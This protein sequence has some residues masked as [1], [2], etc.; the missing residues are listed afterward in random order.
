MPKVTIIVP[1]YN[2]EKYLK[3]CIDSLINQTLKDIEIICINDGSPDNSLKILDEYKKLDDRIVIINK[4]NEGISVARNIGIKISKGEYIGFCDSDDYVDFD[5]FE[6]LYN[7]AKENNC[8]I[9]VGGIKR[10]KDGKIKDFYTCYQS[11]FGKIFKD[12]LILTNTPDYNYVWNKIY[13]KEYLLNNNLEFEPN[14]LFED[15]RFTP[16]A[17]YFANKLITVPNTYYYYVMRKNSIVHTKKN[18]KEHKKS[19]DFE[20]NFLCSRGININEVTTITKR[21]KLF[22]MTILKTKI[23]NGITT[24]Y[25][26]NIIKWQYSK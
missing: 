17:I 21:Y 23:K 15:M 1:V 16:Q 5:Y 10:V 19:Y 2:T 11:K 6:N 14:I 24:Y 3:K 7:S 26:F 4:Y 18:I 20:I 25:L 8:D 13:K 12:K 9:A 22:G